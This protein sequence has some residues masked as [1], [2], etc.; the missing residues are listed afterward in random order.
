MLF[1]LPPSLL[2]VLATSASM[3]VIMIVTLWLIGL[4]D[5]ERGLILGALSRFGGI[6]KNFRGGMK[7]VGAE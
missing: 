1:L 5:A 4:S 7:K 6:L 2:R 3:V